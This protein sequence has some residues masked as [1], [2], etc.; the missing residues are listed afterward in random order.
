MIRPPISPRLAVSA[1]ALLALVLVPGSAQAAARAPARPAAARA[2][3]PACNPDDPLHPTGSLRPAG[4]PA[5]TPGSLMARI[6]ARG[7]LIAGVDLTLF[8]LSHQNPLDGQIE[9]F[10]IDMLHAISAAIFGSPD[11]IRF[12]SLQD[13]ARLPAVES[14]AVDVVA[15]P[16]TVTCA[17][18]RL[19]D[20]STVYITTHQRVLVLDDSRVTNIGQL[21]GQRVCGVI[22]AGSFAELQALAKAPPHIVPVGM[23]YWTDCLVA[24]QQGTVAAVSGDDAILAAQDSDTRMVGPTIVAKP[25][26]LALPASHPEFVRFV[27]AVLAQWR[28]DGGWAASYARWIGRPAPAP[29]ALRYAG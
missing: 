27:N 25:Q 8:H 19:V 28:A 7:Y 12:V 2:A 17:R 6:R 4:P 3:V 10:N 20:F 24:L 21:G 11:R 16:T 18:L 26:G 5:V 22:G 15:Q 23:P 1:A 14:G 13:A 29:P 9:G